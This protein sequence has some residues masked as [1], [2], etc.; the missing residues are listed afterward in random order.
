MIC[1][2]KVSRHLPREKVCGFAA[3][4]LDNLQFDTDIKGGKRCCLKHF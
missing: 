2:E 4:N 3:K 1:K